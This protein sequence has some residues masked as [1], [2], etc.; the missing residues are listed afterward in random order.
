M[1][2]TKQVK[3]RI[4]ENAAKE[5]FAPSLLEYWK[6]VEGQF[7]DLVKHVFKDFD[8]E[9]AKPYRQYINW[10]NTIR[11]HNLPEEWNIHYH[12]F[13]GVCGLPS[14]LHIDLPFEYPSRY[15]HDEY[16]DS[17]YK[18]RT[19]DILRPY[20]VRYFTAKKRYEDIC[21]VLLGVNTCKQLQDTVPELMKYLPKTEGG[22]VTALVPIEQ[23]NRVRSLLTGAH[24][25]AT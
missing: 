13:R 4:A 17:A 18:K 8:W 22:V 3:Q 6:I 15:N 11:L 14:I 25:Q 9:H 19:E 21:Q 5:L 23:I 1:K 7:T 20:M 2:L 12:D 24:G 16:L 10:H